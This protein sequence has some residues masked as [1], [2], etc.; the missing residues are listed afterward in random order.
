MDSRE[1]YIRAV[2]FD[3]PD[4]VPIMHCTL[5]GA[6]QIHGP[7]L[8]AL[9]NRYPSDVLLSS[10]T[11][12]PFAFTGSE[13]GHW[14]DGAVTYDDWGCGWLWNTP[15]YMG[16]AV[17]HPLQ[18]WRELSSYKSPDPMT[19]Q[20]GVALMAEEVSADSHEHFVFVD[21][22]ELF[23]RMI[24]L[25]GMEEIMLDLHE[26]RDEVFALRDQIMDVCLQRIQY[27]GKTGVVD[28]MILRDDW[29]TQEAL[30]I[31]PQV[32]RS[33]FKPAYQKLV[34]AIHETG[35]CVSFHSD[36]V[37]DE[38]LP[39][40][41]EIGCD[42]VNPQAHVMDIAELGRKFGGKV[43][44]RADIDRQY[45]LPHGTPEEVEQLIRSFYTAFGSSKGGYAG[46]AEMSSDVPLA[47]GEAALATFYNLS[48]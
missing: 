4:R 19:G 23:Q 17:H 48:D 31:R 27:W 14:A 11:R 38:I 30:M 24:F 9:Y 6:W 33:V 5:K 32:W 20:E 39:D 22:G 13:R 7:A 3:S 12:G 15:E 42:E 34:D 45:A 37:I 2:T 36:G 26:A 16:Q 29:G 21:G 35:A 1:R 8:E 25:R 18:D 47:N 43:C 28:G 46:W 44:V 41:V 40:L 10:Q